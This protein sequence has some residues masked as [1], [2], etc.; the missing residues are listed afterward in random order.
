MDIPIR[1]SQIKE[2]VLETGV[3]LVVMP[4]VIFPQPLTVE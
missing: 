1:R 2:G 3:F 4:G